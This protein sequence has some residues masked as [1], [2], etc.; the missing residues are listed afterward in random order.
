MGEIRRSSAARIR[1]IPAEQC[2]LRPTQSLCE[3]ETDRSATKEHAPSLLH[4]ENP[5]RKENAF[6]AVVIQRSGKTPPIATANVQRKSITRIIQYRAFIHPS[7]RHAESQKLITRRKVQ[8]QNLFIY[9]T[10]PAESLLTFLFR[11][12]ARGARKL[13]IKYQASHGATSHA[14]I[15]RLYLEME[16]TSQFQRIILS[17]FDSNILSAI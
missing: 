9:N 16:K 1:G 2:I 6:C 14:G 5:S 17:Y 8:I 12:Y 7:F 3:V 15:T 10:S 13:K 4:G 11:S